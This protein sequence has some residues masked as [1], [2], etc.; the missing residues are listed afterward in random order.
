MQVIDLGE[1][2]RD[3]QIAIQR[4]D[5]QVRR[6]QY[7]EVPG[8]SPLEPR[9]KHHRNR[10]HR[11]SHKGDQYRQAHQHRKQ[12]AVLQPEHRKCDHTS[13]PDG[14]DFPE[15]APNIVADLAVHFGPDLADQLM[16]ARCKAA[17]P[18]NQRCLVLHHEEDQDRHQ[19]E[20][21]QDGN[22]THH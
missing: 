6:H 8:K 4:L 16:L 11:S 15:F 13:K 5:D 18:G 10:N 7:K 2:H 17:H 19:D 14:Q 12:H 22:E 3:Q 1:E 20:I 21:D 9:D